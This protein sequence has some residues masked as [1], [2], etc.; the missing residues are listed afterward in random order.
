MTSRWALTHPVSVKEHEKL[1]K[2]QM[3]PDFL[4][5]VPWYSGYLIAMF[6]LL[7]YCFQ[8]NIADFQLVCLTM[9][10]TMLQDI[11]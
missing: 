7:F 1:K 10:V 2:K 6:S 5:M 3:K 11:R 8:H 9:L 4:D